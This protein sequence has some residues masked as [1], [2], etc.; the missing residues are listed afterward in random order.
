MTKETYNKAAQLNRDI[1]EIE[2]HLWKA[3]EDKKWITISTPYR[4]NNCLSS[5]FQKELVG[6]LEQKL[7]EYQREF[8]EL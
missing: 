1:N 4:Q 8:D 7:K 5:N 2:Y 6:W 3:K